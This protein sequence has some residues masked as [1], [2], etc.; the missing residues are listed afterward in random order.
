M[1]RAARL[2]LLAATLACGPAALAQEAPA[3]APAP[4]PDA[5]TARTLADIRQDLAVLAV[6]IARLGRELSTTGPSEV[7]LPASALER[8]DALEAEVRRVTA[9][10]EELTGRVDR[11]VEDGTR[12][13]GD[14]E[15]RL[16]ELGGADLAALPD[17]P[18]LGGEAP[19]APAPAAPSVDGELAVGE[20]RDFDAARG[21]YDAGD[22]AAAA[23][24]FSA[25]AQTYPASPLVPEA[26]L[27]E[28]ESLAAQG[29]SAG[30]ARAFLASFSGAPGAAT[31]RRAL[32]RLGDALARLGQTREACL[33]YIE[34]E[35]RFPEAAEAATARSQA[36]ALGCT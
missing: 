31:S 32:L 36:A 33:T 26:K 19:A 1:R 5:E 14:I 16:A 23:A 28:G 2:L 13:I 34:V 6:E 29:E 17:T 27:L 10:T 11:V 4:A 3:Q 30:A 18:P 20:R 35:S 15:F 22:H 12:R 8:L 24:A 9:A 25:F 21:L 7:R